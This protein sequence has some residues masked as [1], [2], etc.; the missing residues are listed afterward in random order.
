[1]QAA[2]LG[3]RS[4]QPDP[5]HHRHQVEDAVTVDAQLELGHD[6]GESLNFFTVTADIGV[7]SRPV[8]GAVDAIVL[9]AAAVI[10]PWTARNVFLVHDAVLIAAATSFILPLVPMWTTLS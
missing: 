7:P 8:V 3:F 2:H 10:L 1:M 6:L 9:G 4:R 5:H